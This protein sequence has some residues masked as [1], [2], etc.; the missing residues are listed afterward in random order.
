MKPLLARIAELKSGCA[1]E[2]AIEA[3]WLHARDCRECLFDAEP[4]LRQA[5]EAL[6]A[7]VAHQ[8]Q[9]G[10]SSPRRLSSEFIAKVHEA[11]AAGGETP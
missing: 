7:I 1:S 11:L 8:E 2:L 6:R 3:D 5:V 9:C 10:P 4:V